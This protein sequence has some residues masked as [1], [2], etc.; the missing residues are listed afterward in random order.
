MKL[1]PLAFDRL[2]ST[3][4]LGQLF[5]W[6]R[7]YVCP[8]STEYS[9]AASE[10]CPVCGGKGR[11]WGEPTEG[12]AGM[13]G[14]GLKRRY[15]EFGRFEPGDAMLT[16][17]EDSPLYYMGEFD[18]VLMLNSSSPFS[19]VLRRGVN[20]R[21]FY[22][23]VDNIDRVFWLDPADGATIIDGTIPDV[24][25]DSTLI[26]APGDGPPDGVQYS[27]TGIATDEF[28]V[29]L[30]IPSN[31]NAGTGPLP[32]KVIVRKWDLFGR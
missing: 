10:T 8:C 22:T 25:E 2:L 1:N 13:T 15:A 28:F 16:I 4:N 32:K 17:P 19:L 21:L 14:Q 20:D 26:W 30:E 7:A 11:T 6:R 5:L 3:Q 9:G 27:V 18:R 29:Y 24:A 12:H 23:D 31:R